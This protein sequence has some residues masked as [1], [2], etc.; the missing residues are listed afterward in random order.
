MKIGIWQRIGAPGDKQANLAAL[1]QNARA[2][3]AA[4]AKLLLCPECYLAGYNVAD[5]IKALAE[6]VDGPAARQISEI[7]R[8]ENIAIVYGYAE[9][10]LKSNDIFNA[11]QAIGP[12][13]A[14]LGHYR[15]THLFGA[16]EHA[17]YKPGNGFSE[18]FMLNGWKIGMLI[19]YDV[20]FPEAVRSVALSGAELIL[21][22]TALTKEYSAVPEYI[23]PARAVE[24]QVFIAYCNHA[25]MEN[26]MNFLG[27]SRLAGP[28]G[29]IDKVTEDG[30]T[31]LIAQISHERLQ[32]CAQIY[33]YRQDR[34]REL[35][36]RLV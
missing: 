33:P 28:D 17:I 26:N 3:S 19:C 24:N 14:A 7:A 18:P 27:L 16:F 8:R 12:G 15:K 31:L 25:G 30:D 6:P 5:D 23:V 22:P 10:D 11:V 32:A 35:Y 13:G 1:A 21:I 2:A 36:G 34:R 9:H 29:K 4:G 20:E